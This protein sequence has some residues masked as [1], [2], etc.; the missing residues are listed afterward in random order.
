[1][2]YRIEASYQAE[3][4]FIN[5]MNY[6]SSDLYNSQAALDFSAEVKKRIDLL[7]ESPYLYEKIEGTYFDNLA[8]RKIPIK[9]YIVI[10]QVDENKKIIKIMRF[11]SQR[12]N[13]L[14]NL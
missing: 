14:E 5:I 12:Q 2:A 13:Y 9:N 8:F 11:F 6:L 7:Y 4:D 1:M 3:N 10:Y